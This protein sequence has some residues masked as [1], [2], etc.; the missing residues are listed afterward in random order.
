MK[1]KFN[2]KLTIFL[3]SL[4]IAL[5][6]IVLGRGNKFCQSFGLIFIGVAL[7]IF[8]WYFN[9]VI[10]KS[11]VEVDKQI[12]DLEKD[13]ELS[14]EETQYAYKQLYARQGLLY[15]KKKSVAILFSL[16]GGFIIVLSIVAM[17]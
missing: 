11:L 5:M 1:F 4:F 14:E 17:F 16:T 7:F 6:L 3:V 13:D 12:K 8:A 15:K 9:D 2:F 10:Y